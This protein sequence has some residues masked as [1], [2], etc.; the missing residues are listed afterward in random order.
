[1]AAVDF[2][3][4]RILGALTICRI[5]LAFI[6]MYAVFGCLANPLW[7]LAEEQ[8]GETAI[9][10]I[11]VN[12]EKKGEYIVKMFTNG[13]FL[14]Y[15]E[16]FHAL[17]FVDPKGRS[18]E[19]DGKTYISLKSLV[20]VKYAYNQN[21]L[22]LNILAEPG[23]L[24]KHI[25]DF[26][27]AR[28]PKVLYPQ[29]NSLFLNYGFSHNASDS[30]KFESLSA[31]QQLG[32]R[33]SD[34][35]FL[36]DSMFTK[37]NDDSSFTRL[38]TSITH[39]NRSTMQRWVAGDFYTSSGAVGSTLQMGG[40]SFS[41]NFT[42]NPY[43][44]KQPTFNYAGFAKLPSEVNVYLDGVRIR[45]EK[46]SPGGFDLK[47]IM[48]FSGTHDLEISVKDAFG[49]EERL[50]YPLYFTETLLS[51]G[52]QEYSYNAGFLRDSYG[53]ESNSYS[54]MAVSAFHRYGVTESA[55]VGIRGEGTRNLLNI[56]P[57]LTYGLG[58]YGV[59]DGTVVGS[60]G[61]SLK[62][63]FAGSLNHSYLGKHFNTRLLF[64][65]Y[66]E[67]Y[68]TVNT[69][70]TNQI[71]VEK[72]RYQVG[73][74]I[75]YG[76]KSLGSLSFDFTRVS[77]Y[78]GD[79]QQAFSVSYSRSLTR[80]LS[81]SL[82]FRHVEQR[83][84]DN[85]VFVGFTYY[86]G[87]DTTLSTNYQRDQNTQ[88]GMIQL[89]KNPPL[90]EGLSYR[91]SIEE[92]ESHGSMSTAV[93]PYLQYN[94]RYGIYSAEYR[95]RY[96]K[97]KT[98]D[99]TYQFSAGGSIVYVGNTIGFS[100]PVNDSF[101]LIKVGNLPGVRAYYNNQEIGKTDGAGKV[102]IPNLGSYVENYLSINDKDIPVNYSITGVN[103]YVAPALRG[104]TLLKFEATKTQ[105][106]TGTLS[107]RANGS[108]MP[109][110]YYEIL[111][112]IPGKEVK[113]QTARG[114]EFY[115]ENIPP[116]TYKAEFVFEGKSRSF[117]LTIPE[118]NDMIIDL[119]GIVI[120]NTK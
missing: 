69:Q 60:A 31:T 34:I 85:Q 110:E 67:E 78:S 112:N 111:I 9:V 61:E 75:G 89:Q 10:S 62:P 46:L 36:S 70:N 47:N 99:E 81:L 77:K 40:I 98:A 117:R 108:V 83:D 32:V 90:G 58:Q 44:L 119:G 92:K 80:E 43:F 64:V 87:K 22:S 37:S 115:L 65:G 25:V 33:V 97:D 42:I 84:P 116:G 38:M 16:D 18:I 54:N 72:T 41:K 120:E 51:R 17:G 82:S 95:G 73:A 102:V 15:K 91:A 68:G 74:G 35:L 7:V 24:K 105:A 113:C 5:R 29:D 55:T 4:A 96:E 59:V 114:G 2:D 56:G 49:R 93:N 48:A 50:K 1:M 26:T 109:A 30:L 23:L 52:G 27:N 76:N 88:S 86:P 19:V 21:K 13:D 79:D 45:N 12:E 20:G 11:F 28:Q 66:T 71:A 8:A 106:M 63:G 100:R 14:I 101:A 103:R 39:D 94:G 6:L 107:I 53:V 57:Q 3:A 118:S 104:G